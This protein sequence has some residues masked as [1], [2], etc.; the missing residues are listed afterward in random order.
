[1]GLFLHLPLS[2]WSFSPDLAISIRLSLTPLAL[3]VEVTRNAGH[4][5]TRTRCSGFYVTVLLFA[6]AG[7]KPPPEGPGKKCWSDGRSTMG[8]GDR[9]CRFNLSHP[10]GPH[11]SAAEL[12]ESTKAGLSARRFCLFCS[13]RSLA[14]RG[15]CSPSN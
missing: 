4:A 15:S 14:S 11:V 10:R 13:Q 7:W 5:A 3:V 8:F 1:M 12:L 2:I 9:C 6:V